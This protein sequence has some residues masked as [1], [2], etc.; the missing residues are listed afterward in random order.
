M[1]HTVDARSDAPTDGSRQLAPLGVLLLENTWLDMPGALA[2]QLTFG[3]R[4]RYDTVPGAT[5]RRVIG[6]EFARM[7]NG[8][9][10]ASLESVAGG[11]RVLT[12]NCGFAVAYNDAVRDATN[13]PTALSS[14]MML[15]LLV[16]VYP[17]VG[18]LTYDATRLDKRRRM[19]VPWPDAD[20]PV[21]D[22]MSSAA[23]RVLEE[24]EPPELD[25]P[26]MRSDLLE[27]A[28]TVVGAYELDCV[29][30]E[31]TGMAPFAADVATEAAVAVFDITDLVRLI[32]SAP[33]QHK[34]FEDD[35][36]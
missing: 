3:G 28:R 23:W 29:L 26:Q 14:L 24:E 10:E 35:S 8:Y 18:V 15:P 4:V 20:V 22:V 5:G 31:C 25:V 2:R 6:P 36:V 12:S 9:V 19:L 7:V 11:S 13:L 32:R 1:N 33:G 34:G 30:M 27:V 17:R 21:A 16:R